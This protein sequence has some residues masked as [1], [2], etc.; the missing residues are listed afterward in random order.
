ME[1][2]PIL[3][4]P[5]DAGRNREHEPEPDALGV[6]LGSTRPWDHGQV[7][8]TRRVAA[9]AWGVA[10]ANVLAGLWAVAVLTGAV[11]CAGILCSLSTL[12]GHPVLLLILTSCCVVMTIALAAVTSGMSRVNSWQ[13]AILVVIATIGTGTVLGAALVLLL[14]AAAVTLVGGFLLVL[15]ERA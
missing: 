5:P 1:S 4:V 9:L 15:L 12:G 11:P 13:L 10:A 14:I 2:S 8:L 7:P 3:S 6:F